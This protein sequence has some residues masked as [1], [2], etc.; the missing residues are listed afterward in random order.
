MLYDN[1]SIRIYMPYITRYPRSLQLGKIHQQNAINN[2][3]LDQ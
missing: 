2:K 3:G 1:L